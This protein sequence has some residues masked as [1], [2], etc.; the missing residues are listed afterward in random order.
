MNCLTQ[1]MISSRSGMCS[2]SDLKRCWKCWVG[3]TASWWTT[4]RRQRFHIKTTNDAHQED[5]CL[6]PF[7]S[8]PCRVKDTVR[9]T[10]RKTSV[11]R[12]MTHVHGSEDFMSLGSQFFYSNDTRIE[13]IPV[14]FWAD[15]YGNWQQSQMGGDY[16]ANRL[17]MLSKKTISWQDRKWLQRLK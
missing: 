9:R 3:V 12:G 2:S 7:C 8:T 15:W 5:V 10:L 13:Q 1:V 17:S 11:K 4:C 16:N 6:H 14:G